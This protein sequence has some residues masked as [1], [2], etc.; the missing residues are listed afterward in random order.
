MKKFLFRSLLIL[1]AMSMMTMVGCKHD[2][3]DDPIIP[4]V[5]P[6]ADEPGKVAERF[7]G[8]FI[9]NGGHK[10][11]IVLTE[12]KLTT[13]IKDE[14][15]PNGITRSAYTIG[16]DLYADLSRVLTGTTII[17]IGSFDSGPD[18]QNKLKVT[19]DASNVYL[20]KDRTYNRVQ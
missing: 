11:Q 17:K 6:P 4:V 5:P 20:F 16:N 15:S 10:Y 9:F 14:P 2:T 3:D 18:S 7:R 8:T 1:M 13:S 19:V 12:D